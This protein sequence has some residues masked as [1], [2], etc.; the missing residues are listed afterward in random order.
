M[1]RLVKIRPVIID[2]KCK[3]CELCVDNCQKGAIMIE[4]DDGKKIKIDVEICSLCGT[5]VLVC[6][7]SAIRL[8]VF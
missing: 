8:C 5:C 6:P 1:Y 2:E 7:V 3:R 4:K